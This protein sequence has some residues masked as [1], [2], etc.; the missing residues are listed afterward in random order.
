MVKPPT[1]GQMREI[2][3]YYNLELSD[4]NVHSF[5]GFIEGT[6]A[7][8][9]RLDQLVELAPEVRYPGSGGRRPEPEENPL[10]A[11][12]RPRTSPVRSRWPMMR[13]KSPTTACSCRPCR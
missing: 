10:G 9:N 7:S 3:A 2:S 12:P 13:C 5:L 8:N 6:R 11:W 4:A 1:A